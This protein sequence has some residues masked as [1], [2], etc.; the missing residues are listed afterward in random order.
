MSVCVVVGAG[1][2]VGLAVARRFAREGFTVA[3]SA[4]SADRLQSYIADM[5]GMDVHA[6][7][8]DA[9]DFDSVRVLF[10][11]IQAKLGTVD[12][13]VYNIAVVSSQPPPSEMSPQVL[14]D[15]FRVNVASALVCAQQ[16]IP[17]MRA[18]QQGTILFTGGGLSLYPN[19]AYASLAVG[20]AAL[21]NLTFSLAAEL[22]AD[23][24]Q[25]ATV[26]I[27]GGVQPGTF[28]DPDK[29]ADEYWRLHG[30]PASANEHEFIFAR[31]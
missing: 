31:P 22:A 12:V 2:G 16:V 20:K 9:G 17:A 4:R 3:L 10:A 28:F 25:V 29:I 14:I 26:T 23:N 18:R 6:F 19:P 11:D 21:R 24:I 15:E 13:L 7:P 5:P 30:V 1:A 27:A 8:V